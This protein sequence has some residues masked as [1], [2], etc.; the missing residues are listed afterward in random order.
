MTA[1]DR[2]KDYS[3]PK[4]H[5]SCMGVD[6]EPRGDKDPHIMFTLCVEDDELWHRKM[7][8]SSSWLPELIRALQEAQAFCETQA[9]SMSNGRQ[10][11]WEFKEP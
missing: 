1:S 6:L 10:Y 3:P 7:S 2:P 9:P 11:G 5:G 4:F 8:V